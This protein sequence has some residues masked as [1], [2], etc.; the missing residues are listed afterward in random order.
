M[1][2]T[3]DLLEMITA[4]KI[5]L[6]QAQARVDDAAGPRPASIHQKDDIG[7]RLQ[8]LREQLTTAAAG[9]QVLQLTV[10]T[11]TTGPAGDGAAELPPHLTARAVRLLRQA[12]DLLGQLRTLENE[13][14]L[15]AD[16]SHPASAY[17]CETV[18]LADLALRS[19]QMLPE[20]PSLQQRLSS[21][22]DALLLQLRQRTEILAGLQLRER[23]EE[24]QLDEL[25]RL[26]LQ[27]RKRELPD[28]NGFFGLAEKLVQEASEGRPMRLPVHAPRQ[29]I[30]F[31]AAHSLATAR[32]LVRIARNDPAWRARLL[33][34][35]VAALVHDV[36]MLAVPAN[37]HAQ[38]ANFSAEQ[39]M[40]VE[41]HCALGARWVSHVQPAHPWLIAATRNHHERLDG[42]GY[43]AG[44][45]GPQLD[46]LVRLVAVA[47]VYASLCSARPHR[48]ARECNAALSEI[49][50]LA[51]EGK[52]DDS[53]VRLLL[54]LSPYPPGTA[55]ELQDGSCGVVLAVSPG[56]QGAGGIAHPVVALLTDA[57]GR[58]LPCPQV[59]DL[60]FC[61]HRPVARAIPPDRR[62]RLFGSS[63]P[64][65]A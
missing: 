63:Y 6:E 37:F 8:H 43:P 24:E 50:Q 28:W 39:W 21:G 42:V 58:P 51:D 14:G 27:L 54:E 19:I 18:L 22:L 56:S 45:R 9:Q 32:V 2:N 4:L 60:A 3:H 38:P 41:R 12:H 29:V 31:V 23:E 47:D 25:C 57:Q 20:Q 13:V 62:R 1:S 5:R 26:L 49:L 15:S 55:I 61:D 16:E 52:L 34:P 10:Q 48:P 59:V 17:F 33:Q 44:L 35:V 40:V 36:G 11:A 64:Q 30:R 53:V 46:P 65:W 7:V